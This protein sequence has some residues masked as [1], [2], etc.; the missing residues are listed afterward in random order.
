ME[1]PNPHNNGLGFNALWPI[2]KGE[3]TEADSSHIPAQSVCSYQEVL[4][5]D[6]RLRHN[7]FLLPFATLSLD[8]YN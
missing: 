1:E 4:Q 6:F 8:V 5:R 2:G 7:N 3:A